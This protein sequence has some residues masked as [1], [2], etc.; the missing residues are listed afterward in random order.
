MRQGILA[1]LGSFLQMTAVW[2]NLQLF[3]WSCENILGNRKTTLEQVARSNAN[4]C[5]L[6]VVCAKGKNI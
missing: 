5:H 2:G 3:Q 6:I 4:I 1:N